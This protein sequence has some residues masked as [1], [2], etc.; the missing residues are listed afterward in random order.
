[1]TPEANRLLAAGAQSWLFG[2]MG[3]W[4]DL[5]LDDPSATDRLQRVTRNLYRSMLQAFIAAT[6]SDF[7][8]NAAT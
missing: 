5:W 6:N 2:G 4:N 1:M 8:P 3:S 7:R